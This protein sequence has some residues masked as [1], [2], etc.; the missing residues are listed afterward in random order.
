MAS[1]E[2]RN[3]PPEVLNIVVKAVDIYAEFLLPPH[4]DSIKIITRHKGD[5]G[6]LI[7]E[8]FMLQKLPQDLFCFRCNRTYIVSLFGGA[9]IDLPIETVDLVFN[10]KNINKD[11]IFVSHTEPSGKY[12]TGVEIKMPDLEKEDPEVANVLDNLQLGLLLVL[13]RHCKSRGLF[14]EMSIRVKKLVIDSYG[15]EEGEELWRKAMQEK[16]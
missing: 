11:G 13:M 7:R 1:P 9:E 12:S 10:L 14:S 15:Y 8:A 16:S 2:R 6:Q 5:D 4:Q 3:P